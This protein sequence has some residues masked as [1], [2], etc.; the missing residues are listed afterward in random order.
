MQRKR[1]KDSSE[2]IA[3][4]VVQKMK[5]TKTTKD[6]S[7]DNKL[8]VPSGSTLF[9]LALSDSESG[10]WQVGKIVNII[11]DSSS[12]KTFLAL[13]CFAEMAQ[14]KEFDNYA[15]IYD[16]VEAANEFNMKK[17]FGKASKRIVAPCRIDVTHSASRG[18][19][20]L[21]KN[22]DTIQDFQ[23]YIDGWLNDERPFVY[24]LDSLDALASEEGLE[25][26]DREIEARRAGKKISGT[27]G[28]EKAKKLSQI[29]RQIKSKIAKTESLLIIISQT[30]DNIDPMSFT[31]KTRSGGRALNFY[32]THE[33]W[34]A[35]SKRIRK[36]NIQIGINCK[37]KISKN[38]LTG[39]I[40]EVEFP[41]YYDYGIDDIGSCISWMVSE[42]FWKMKGRTIDAAY[43]DFQGTME[44]L[45][46]EVE[47]NDLEQN[48]LPRLRGCIGHHWRKREES[49]KLNRR[50]K[51]E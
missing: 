4:Q 50:S 28:M 41:I 21:S 22:S 8:L 14:R 24:V 33:V 19:E 34:T 25:K 7:L 23:S 32:C 29:L 12:G 30:R 37:V 26:T 16:D 43:L 49:L 44:K 48:L 17:L 3:E 42:G 46:K 31:K 11:G 36:R 38:K 6:N 1:R 39:K 51:Y 5:R 10:G 15:F 9:N 18:R 47:S 40:R 20:Y 13:S 27:Y 45:I 35:V 2:D